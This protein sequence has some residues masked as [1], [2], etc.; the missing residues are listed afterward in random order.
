MVTVTVVGGGMAASDGLPR[1]WQTATLDRRSI[2]WRR[3]RRTSCRRVAQPMAAEAG[4]ARE[5]RAAEMEAG[6]ARE[7]QP[8]EG[9]RIGARGAYG[10]GGRL[11]ARGAAG[12]GRSDLGAWW[13]CRWVWRGL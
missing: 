9:G 4:S 2:V 6:L 5:A 8:M 11:G 12:G 13:S 7:A 3:G 10:G 1:A